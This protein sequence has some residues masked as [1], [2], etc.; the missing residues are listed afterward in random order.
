M[1]ELEYQNLACALSALTVFRGILK[2]PPMD[3]LLRFLRNTEGERAGMELYGAFVYSLASDNYSLSSFLKRA[4]FADENACAV[5]AGRQK[6]GKGGIPAV[7]RDNMSAELELFSTLTHLTPEDLCSPPTYR[8]YIPKFANTPVD[9]PSAYAERLGNIRRCGYGVFSTASMFRVDE[10]GE[11]VPIQTADDVSME[12]FVGYEEQRNE[13]FANTR[14][15][16][17]GKSA[18]NA[19]LYGD[20]GTGKS[21]TVKACVNRFAGEGLRLIELR[22]DQLF[23]LPHVMGAI[24]GNPLRFIIFV[25]DLSFQSNDDSFSML[26]AALEGSAA[27]KAENAVIYAT[28]NR[29]HIVKESFSDRNAG[30]D[31]HR[32]DT[33]QELISLSDR[34]GLTVFFPKPDKELYLRIVRSLAK[35]QGVKLQQEELERK[36]EAF[37]LAKGSRSP[38]AAEQFIQ[39]LQIEI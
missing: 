30:D 9:F 2:L 7:L 19:L 1:T 5:A 36:A 29:R 3:A 21:S 26:K 10:A 31:I 34:F 18:A 24:S 6:K 11:I 33:M 17:N 35:R 15:L 23:A 12:L 37:A 14:L 8:G 22:K 25:D 16:L 27:A 28:S 4:V 13:I 32:R 38:R 39:S 20:A